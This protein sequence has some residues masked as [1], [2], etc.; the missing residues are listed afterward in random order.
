MILPFHTYVHIDQGPWRALDWP[1][2]HTHPHFTF[3]KE[4]SIIDLG[5]H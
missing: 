5:H 1:Q 2:A 4:G 3:F